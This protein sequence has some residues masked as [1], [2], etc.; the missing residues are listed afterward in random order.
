MMS[1]IA[2]ASIVPSTTPSRTL[3]STSPKTKPVSSSSLMV[4]SIAA[5]IRSRSIVTTV[6]SISDTS[7]TK[8]K[9]IPDSSE[10]SAM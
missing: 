8:S 2:A 6:V 9:S 1:S 3:S 7:R 5:S 4:P 10:L